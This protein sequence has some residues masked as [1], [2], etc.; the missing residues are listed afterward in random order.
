M[1]IVLLAIFVLFFISF[2][3]SKENF[4]KFKYGTRKPLGEKQLKCDYRYKACVDRSNGINLFYPDN[5]RP[6]SYSKGYCD[7]IYQ[8]CS[9]AANNNPY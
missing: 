1:I 5:N 4:S 9:T 8:R 7:E 6:P 2:R 3:C